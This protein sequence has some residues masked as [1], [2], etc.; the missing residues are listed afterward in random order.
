[1]ELFP[2]F[3][4]TMGEVA[5]EDERRDGELWD[6]GNAGDPGDALGPLLLQKAIC[7]PTVKGLLKLSHL[8]LSL[9]FVVSGSVVSD[10]L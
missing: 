3:C 4:G 10:Y 1:M 2:E 9:L 7:S 5:W 6:S 8:Y